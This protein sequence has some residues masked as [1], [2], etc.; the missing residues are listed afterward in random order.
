MLLT[1]ETVLISQCLIKEMEATT[2]Y[3]CIQPYVVDIK[4]ERHTS[5]RKTLLISAK[6]THRLY[7]IYLTQSRTDTEFYPFDSMVCYRLHTLHLL[8]MICTCDLT[9]TLLRSVTTLAATWLATHAVIKL[10]SKFI[11][12]C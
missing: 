4:Y 7:C 9:C 5:L 3:S 12:H 11:L 2:V 10:G 1:F 8:D 6:L